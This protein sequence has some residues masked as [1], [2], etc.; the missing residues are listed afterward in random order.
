MDYNLLLQLPPLQGHQGCGY[1]G[2]AGWGQLLVRVL[3]G[4][5]LARGHIADNGCL[6]RHFRHGQGGDGLDLMGIET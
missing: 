1:F 6:G 2:G 4:Q 5:Y 3:L